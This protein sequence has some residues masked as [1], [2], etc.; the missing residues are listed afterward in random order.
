VIILLHLLELLGSGVDRLTSDVAVDKA[1]GEFSRVDYTKTKLWFAP[2]VVM[3]KR[4][5]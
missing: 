1:M 2:L 4:Y 3:C 5:H